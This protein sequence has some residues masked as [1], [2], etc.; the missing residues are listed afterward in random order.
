MRYLHKCGIFHRQLHPSNILLDEND[1]IRIGDFRTAQLADIVMTDDYTPKGHQYCYAAPEILD[2]DRCYWRPTSDV[3]SYAMVLW[4]ILTG[5]SVATGYHERKDLGFIA[6]HRRI[7]GNERPSTRDLEPNAI[8]L[9]MACWGTPPGYRLSCDEILDY[10]R[11]NNYAI[12]PD[13]NEAEIARYVAQL[14]QYEE[15]YPPENVST[16]DHE[17]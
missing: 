3:F 5:R 17:E 13:V 2:D 15:K 14:E 12:L 1:E 6:H 9:L 7:N 11:T 10:F 16:E 4:E 8:R